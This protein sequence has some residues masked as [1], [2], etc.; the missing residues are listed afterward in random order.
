MQITNDI[1]IKIAKETG[2]DLIGFA[3]AEKLT[4]EVSRL[5][6]WLANGYQAKMSINGKTFP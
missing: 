5:K 4:G 6:N 1:V 3:K 2:F